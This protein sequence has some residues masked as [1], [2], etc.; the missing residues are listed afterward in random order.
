MPSVRPPHAARDESAPTNRHRPRL[1]RVLRVGRRDAV[2]EGKALELQGALPPVDSGQDFAARLPELFVG[3]FLQA[4]H[5]YHQDERCASEGPGP[6]DGLERSVSLAKTPVGPGYAYI[7]LA[8]TGIF[9]AERR[10]SVVEGGIFLDRRGIF[11]AERR[12]SVAE[13]CIFLARPRTFQ[14][15]RRASVAERCI[16]LARTRIF[17][18]GAIVA[19][20]VP[21]IFQPCADSRTSRTRVFPTPARLSRAGS[22]ASPRRMRIFQAGRCTRR[23]AGHFFEAK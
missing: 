10:A 2:R 12:A 23:A 21:R 11:Q 8:R 4:E 17:R 5:R 18:S 15:E 22:G 3:R 20:I 14:A 6:S 7:F 9:Q 19:V 13:R 16:F 1:Q